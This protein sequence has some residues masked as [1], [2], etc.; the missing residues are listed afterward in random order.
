[1]NIKKKKKFGRRDFSL[2]KEKDL[3]GYNLIFYR[4]ERRVRSM[5]P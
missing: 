5:I 3:K 4:I 2:D 1:M